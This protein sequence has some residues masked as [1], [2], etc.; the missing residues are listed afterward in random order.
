[1]QKRKEAKASEGTEVK[2]PP[3]KKRGGKD[4]AGGGDDAENKA[5]QQSPADL[6]R[7]KLDKL[8]GLTQASAT[9][10]A[11]DSSVPPAAGS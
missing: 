7:E 9:P 6:E 1:M 2:K 3:P 11:T 5:K 8:L 10:T 4:G